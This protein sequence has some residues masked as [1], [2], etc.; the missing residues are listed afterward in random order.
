MK[1]VETTLERLW[2]RRDVIKTNDKALEMSREV[3]VARV[4]G[5]VDAFLVDAWKRTRKGARNIHF[6]YG[7]GATT[8]NTVSLTGLIATTVPGVSTPFSG[9]LGGESMKTDS[10][11]LGVEYYFKDNWAVEL[12][13]IFSNAVREDEFVD[14]GTLSYDEEKYVGTFAGVKYCFDVINK[15][16]GGG[17]NGRTRLFANA[18]L[19]LMA[20]YDISGTV[21]FLGSTETVDLASSGDAYFTLGLG[22]GVLYAWTDHIALE[23]GV[24]VVNSITGMDGEWSFS[25]PDGSGG[26]YSGDYSTDLSMTRAYLGVLVGF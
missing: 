12:G 4:Q 26:S 16:G 19:G 18:R 7:F 20:D 25:G 13:A 23:L 22:A 10:S 3:V 24:N 2:Q 6:N 15:S 1:E 14:Y 21:A 5:E 8:N 17:L 11:D 9:S